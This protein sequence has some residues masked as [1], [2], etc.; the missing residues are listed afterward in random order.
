MSPPWNMALVRLGAVKHL[1]G[2]D[3]S[4]LRDKI[5]KSIR[6]GLQKYMGGCQNDGTFLEVVGH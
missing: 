5:L 1:E 6:P 3:T 2:P 4:L